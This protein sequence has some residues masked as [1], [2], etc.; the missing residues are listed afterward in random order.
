MGDLLKNLWRGL[1]MYGADLYWNVLYRARA[2]GV[3]N[4]PKEGGV[5]ICAN[6]I[7][8]AETM[9]IPY[10]VIDAFGRF[11][12][13]RFW[14]PGKEELFKL[15]PFSWLLR[16]W[17]AFPVKRNARDFTAM[18]RIAELSKTDAVMIYPEGTRSK[19]GE[20]GR[21]KPGVGKIIHDSRTTVVPC[22]V[23]NT[24]YCLPRGS[25][26][27]RIRLPLYVVYGKPLDLSRFY[28]MPPSKETST[29]IVNEVM[30]AIKALLEEHEA[31]D[32]RYAEGGAQ[33][34]VMRAAA[35]QPP[36][37]GV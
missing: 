3:E 12:K 7:S 10:F 35:Q 24:R 22:A 34:Q 29:L 26:I 30:A 25:V 17:R 11:S 8:N 2:I 31:L 16:S 20:L 32:L 28:A 19:T 23:F 36:A 18:N 37:G 5:L 9:L 33:A 4:V 27:P 1:C 14:S 6:H 13:R 15:G 21:G